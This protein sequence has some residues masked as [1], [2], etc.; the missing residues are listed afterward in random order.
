MDMSVIIP[1]AAIM[2]GTVFLW[3]KLPAVAADSIIS[4]DCFS[5]FF[6]HSTKS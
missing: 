2:R 6:W 1:K 4:V 5:L 3:L